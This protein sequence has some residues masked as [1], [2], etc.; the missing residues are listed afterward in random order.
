MPQPIHKILAVAE[1]TGMVERIGEFVLTQALE[2]LANLKTMGFD[3]LGLSINLTSKELARKDLV[4]LICSTLETHGLDA[5]VLEFE[6]AESV[7]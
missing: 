2:D 3:A 4:E 7:L 1:R 5:S 6:L